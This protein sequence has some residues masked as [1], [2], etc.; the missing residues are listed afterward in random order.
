MA[1]AKQVGQHGIGMGG[2]PTPAV[3]QMGQ[4]SAASRQAAVAQ[5]LGGM[6]TG[7]NTHPT[8]VVSSAASLP[9]SGARVAAPAKHAAR[10]MPS[11]AMGTQAGISHANSQFQFNTG[12]GSIQPGGLPGTE[13][14]RKAE[15][16]FMLQNLGQSSASAPFPAAANSRA[17]LAAVSVGL[18]GLMGVGAPSKSAPTNMMINQDHS[19]PGENLLAALGN[20]TLETQVR[21]ILARN[22]LT[23]QRKVELIAN[24]IKPSSVIPPGPL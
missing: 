17:A 2:L 11:N 6:Q 3:R 21:H 8:P 22:D 7:Q 23:E 9:Q 13:G 16:P 5:Q 15:A 4:A 18:G 24:L 19:F 20:P 12:A 1:Q 14:V 10:P